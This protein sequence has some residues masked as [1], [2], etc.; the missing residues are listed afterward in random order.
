MSADA[1]TGGA[2]APA[3][4]AAEGWAPRSWRDR[5]AEQ[6][7]AYEDESALEQALGRL[8]VLPPLVVG[9]EIAGLRTQLARVAAGRGFLLQGGDCAESFEAVSAGGARRLFEL[10]EQMRL[11]V[12][13]GLGVDVVTV[14][15]IAGQYAKPRSAPT[16]RVGD[17]E[18][19]SYRGDIINR[20]AATST[21]RRND[22]D[23]L[24]EAYFHAAAT[25][26]HL[27]ADVGARDPDRALAALDA[28]ATQSAQ[29]DRFAPLLAELERAC[30]WAV[31]ADRR[32]APRGPPY[33]S[34]EGLLL[35]FEEALVRQDEESGC[36]FA[37]S[38]HFLWIGERTRRIGGAHL[39][40]LRG[41]ANPIGIKLG[42]KTVPDDL[43]RLVEV[44]DPHAEPGRLVLI[45]RLGHDQ[46]EPVLPALV[47][48]MQR[49]GRTPVW[50]C[51]PMHGNTV[52]SPNG[53]KTRHFRDILA[54]IRGFFDVHR[55][56]G[57]HAGGLHLEMTGEDVTECA[58]G[59]EALTEFHL[60]DRYHTHCDPRLNARQA[61]ELALL[62]AYEQ[63]RTRPAARR[64][65]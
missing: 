7:P 19:P 9:R 23:N 8:A 30:S 5:P 22:P 42:P 43:R 1:R 47:Q 14:A 24:L 37:G 38:A 61:L 62:V 41:I 51:D 4:H 28:F 60:G 57:S 26:N 52:K 15:R 49:D 35:A 59:S 34:H 29:R 36:W 48:A 32:L 33:T 11:V 40:L 31:A 21:A 3:R 13:Y 18:L 63:G 55:A 56:L 16:E 25:L 2:L 39:E 64:P 46:V 58:G 50:A 20:M 17:V 12:G 53:F 6:Q 27:R 45:T 65:R 44:L 54:E 10:L